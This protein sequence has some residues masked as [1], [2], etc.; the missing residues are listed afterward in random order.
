MFCEVLS[1]NLDAVP[2]EE[3]A[4]PRTSPDHAEAPQGSLPVLR[5]VHPHRD[6]RHSR[7]RPSLPTLGDFRWSR[8]PPSLQLQLRVG[9]GDDD[10]DDGPWV[11]WKQV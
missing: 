6:T 8:F 5:E 7:H 10:Q 9:A 2:G 1:D 4:G 3:A 11:E